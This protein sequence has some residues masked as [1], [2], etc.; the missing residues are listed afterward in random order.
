V[1]AHHVRSRRTIPHLLAQ[2]S[3]RQGAP[4]RA[5]AEQSQTR[6]PSRC[7]VKTTATMPRSRCRARRHLPRP[8]SPPWQLPA[9]AP[10]RRRRSR[11]R[12]CARGSASRSVSRICSSWWSG[13][14]E[15]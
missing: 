4:W 9:T 12:S 1:S 10:R 8:D 11:T 2:R 3:L 15:G 7:E 13:G 6:A 5:V 14:T